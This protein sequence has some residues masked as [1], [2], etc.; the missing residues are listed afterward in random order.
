MKI[1]KD[2]PL[3]KYTSFQIGGLAKYL[4][5]IE[6][7]E[8]LIKAVDFIRE[9]QLPFFIL[10]GGSNVLASDEGY[11]GAAIL[12]KNQERTVGDNKI[13]AEAGVKLNDLVEMSVDCGFSGLE[14]AAGIPGTIAGAIRGNAGAFGKS[15]SES[16][17][18]VKTLSVPLLLRGAKQILFPK[19]AKRVQDYSLSEATVESGVEGSSN[20]IIKDFTPQE[21]QFDY[22][23][24]V[25]KHNQE[26]I[27]AVEFK[28]Q[29]GGKKESQKLISGYLAQR[30]QNCPLEYPSA[31]CIFKNPKPE[32]AG[33][34]IEQV[35]LKGKQIGKA[36]ISEKHA[37]FIINLGQ[38]KAEDVLALIKLAQTEVKTKFNTDLELEIQWLG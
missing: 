22:R 37:N 5:A 6:N 27:L 3:S 15:I 28:F 10:G 11:G 31:G 35:G 2:I 9:K 19:Q 1:Q 12:M 23:E 7:S 32:S 38:A 25:F 29:K 36:M 30:K 24:S 14:W 13:M 4:L 26:I 8:D 16:V 21:C 18:N 17:I 20:L 33:D 34:L